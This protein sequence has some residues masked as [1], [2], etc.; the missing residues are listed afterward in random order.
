LGNELPQNHQELWQRLAENGEGPA[1][2]LELARNPYLLTMM[3]DIF[4]ED[5]QLSQNRAEMMDRF[6]QILL[7]WAKAK[8]PAGEWLDPEV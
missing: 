3:I 2:L 6:T 1:R 5:G 7:G 4:A 8:S